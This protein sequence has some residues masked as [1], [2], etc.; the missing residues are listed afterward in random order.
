M[1]CVTIENVDDLPLDGKNIAIQ[2]KI[3]PGRIY[4]VAV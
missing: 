4:F 3:G 2:T 1:E